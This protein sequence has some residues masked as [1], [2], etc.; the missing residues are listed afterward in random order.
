MNEEFE[1]I[2]RALRIA[3]DY[4]RK[5]RYYAEADLCEEAQADL[6]KIK[7]E[8]PDGAGFVAAPL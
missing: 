6:L 3:A 4:L 8:F 2:K 5:V 7:K 1:N